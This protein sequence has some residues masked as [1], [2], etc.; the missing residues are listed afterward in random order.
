[1]K[2]CVRTLASSS[3]VKR[4]CGLQHVSEAG[5]MVVA[6]CSFYLAV[7]SMHVR[8]QLY[9]FLQKDS[10]SAEGIRNGYKAWVQSVGGVGF[11]LMS[12]HLESVELSV[13]NP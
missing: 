5:T 2:S 12:M 7:L 8:H 9:Q 11:K 3:S 13:H 1:M 10:C 4:S 6:C